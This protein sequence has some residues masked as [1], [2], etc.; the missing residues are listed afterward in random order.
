LTGNWLGIDTASV[1]GGVALLCNGELVMESILPV[2]SFHSEKLLPAVRALME[3]AEIGG[4][5]LSGIGVSVGPGSYT[6]LRIGVATALGLSAGWKVPLKG[7]S[8]L[9][10]IASSL[11]EGHVLSCIRARTGE[12]FA[13][14]F[15]SPDPLSPEIIPQALYSSGTLQEIISEKEFYAAGSGRTEIHSANLRW[16]TPLLDNSRPSLAAACASASAAQNGFDET[17]EPLYLRG[18]NQRIAP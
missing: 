9:R 4:E 3:S 10:I 2:K 1:L 13:G 7:I 18:F 16:T 15:E 6:G 14:A 11:P 8:T 12:V 5:D 17:I